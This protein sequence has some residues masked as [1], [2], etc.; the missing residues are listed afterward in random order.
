MQIKH[1]SQKKKIIIITAAVIVLLT[2]IG[3][4]AYAFFL[5]NKPADTTNLS[6]ATSEEQ[7]AGD[8]AKEATVNNDTGSN[9]SKNS[10]SPSPS[11]SPSTVAMRITASSQNGNVY[12]IRSLIESVVSKGT[13]TLTLTQANKTITK[14]AA[15]QA[16]AQTSTCQGFDIPVSEL[17]I[18]TWDVKINLSGSGFSG[19]TTGTINVQ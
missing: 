5:Q 13:C 18:G 2:I 9:S 17:A 6:P 11:A 12:Q 16:L 1:P 15:T 19:S 4:V 8:Q 3:Y 10:E 14:T 7:K